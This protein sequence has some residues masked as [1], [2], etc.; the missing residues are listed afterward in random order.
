M[1]A[2]RGIVTS[3]FGGM[4]D[5]LSK[6]WSGLWSTFKDSVDNSMRAVSGGSFTWLKDAVA[7]ATNALNEMLKSDRVQQWGNAI[8][9]IIGSCIGVV[10]TYC[11]YLGAWQK[12][13]QAPCRWLSDWQPPV[14]LQSP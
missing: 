9:S 12:L 13:S 7:A 4:T 11:R 5:E 6:T 2:L 1:D 14:L 8:G 10:K 3:N